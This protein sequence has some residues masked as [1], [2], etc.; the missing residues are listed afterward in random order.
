MEYK[1]EQEI[2]KK[3]LP[4]LN[5]GRGNYRIFQNVLFGFDSGPGTFPSRDQ[6][7]SVDVQK[8]IAV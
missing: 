5:I 6:C 3:N 2:L 8:V 7:R 4:P 1:S